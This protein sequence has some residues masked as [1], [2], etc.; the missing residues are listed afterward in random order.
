VKLCRVKGTVVGAAHHP[1]YDGKKLLVVQPL[2]ERG[3]E[4]GASLLAVDVV[5]AGV[6]DLVLVNAEGNGTRQI[7]KQGAIV[8]IRSLVV[9]IVDAVDVPGDAR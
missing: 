7:L 4:Q 1:A 8:P 9:A 2:D 5:Q 6:G 3:A